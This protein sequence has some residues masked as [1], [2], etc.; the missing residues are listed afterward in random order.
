MLTLIL[1]FMLLGS[2]AQPQTPPPQPR[3]NPCDAAEFRQFD[4]W[5]GDWQV[6]GPGGAVIGENTIERIAGNCGIHENWRGAAGGAGRSLNTY[7]R[8]E[9]KWHQVWVGSGGGLL[10]LIGGLEDGKMVLEGRTTGPNNVVTLHRVTWSPLPGGRVRQFWESSTDAGK[11]WTVA[12]DGTYEK[13]AVAL[14]AHA[15]DNARE[16]R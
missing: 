6:K 10:H 12:F 15:R 9:G 7:Q 11:V 14:P 2:Q 1:G 3:P 4:F 8:S 13:K 5:I 16:A